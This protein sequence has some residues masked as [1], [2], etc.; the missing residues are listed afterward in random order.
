[1]YCHLFMVH[2]VRAIHTIPT[3]VTHVQYAVFHCSFPAVYM[4]KSSIL[5]SKKLPASGGG[6]FAPDP[7]TRGSAPGPRWGQSPQ[8]PTIALQYLLFPTNPRRASG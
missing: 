8:A 3:I 2:S 1:M 5:R 7:M 4:Q 6:S